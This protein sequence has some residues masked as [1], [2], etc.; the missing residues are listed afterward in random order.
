[1]EL[2]AFVKDIVDRFPANPGRYPMRVRIEPG[3]VVRG[4]R[5]RL[6]QALLNLLNN[7]L[8]AIEGAGK[9]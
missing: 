5:R 6:E 2:G 9:V 3:L 4:D 1:M 8:D 7:A